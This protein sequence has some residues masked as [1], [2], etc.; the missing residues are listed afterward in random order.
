MLE[1]ELNRRIQADPVHKV[2]LAP[3]SPFPLPPFPSL[4]GSLEKLPLIDRRHQSAWFWFLVPHG[5]ASLRVQFRPP[6]VS[7]PDQ[8]KPIAE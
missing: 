5:C 6:S 4:L 2:H 8:L 3:P 1:V 7:S